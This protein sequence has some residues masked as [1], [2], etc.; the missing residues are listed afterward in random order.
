MSITLHSKTLNHS[1]LTIAAVFLY[2]DAEAIDFVVR[3]TQAGRLKWRRVRNGWHGRNIESDFHR[4]WILS[5]GRLLELAYR[6]K[7]SEKWLARHPKSD[8][9]ALAPL[10]EYLLFNLDAKETTGR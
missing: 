8:C 3:K 1:P 10:Y 2:D 9:V 5:G 6:S 7:P 4:R